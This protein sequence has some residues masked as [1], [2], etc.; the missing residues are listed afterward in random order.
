MADEVITGA[1]EWTFAGGIGWGG[2]RGTDVGLT[3]GAARQACQQYG[4]ALFYRRRMSSPALCG[5]GQHTIDANA[6]PYAQHR[7][8]A[9]DESRGAK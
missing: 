5:C 2:A 3:L 8:W 9:E 4:A 1:D 7:T 6:D